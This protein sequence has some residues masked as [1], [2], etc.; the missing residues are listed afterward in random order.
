MPETKESQLSEV[1]RRGS[2]VGL[3][4]QL[5]AA[6]FTFVFSVLIARLFHAS[7]TGIFFEAIAI[8]A[9]ASNIADI[10]ADDGLIYLMPL[11][12]RSGHLQRLQNFLPK[13]LV[14]IFLFGS[15]FASALFVWAPNI[16]QIFSHHSQNS[17]LVLSLRI[18][19]PFVPLAALVDVLLAGS[20]GLGRFWPALFVT[21]L[22][23]PLLRLALVVIF[24][25]SGIGLVSVA[26]AWGVPVALGVIVLVALLRSFL[27]STAKIAKPID[28]LDKTLLSKFWRVSAPRGA[29]S[30]F[31]LGLVW[32]DVLLVGAIDS[33][34]TAGIYAIANRYLLILTMV[35]AAVGSAFAS[36]ISPLIS[37]RRYKELG[38]LYQSATA[39]IMAAVWPIALLMALFSPVL[40]GIFGKGFGHG[41]S[42]LRVLAIMMMFVSATGNNTAVLV[43][44]GKSGQSLLISIATLGINVALNLIWIPRIGILGAA[45]AWAVSLIFA[46]IAVSYSLWHSYRLTPFS[47]SWNKVAIGSLLVVGG[48]G[49]L[50]VAIDGAHFG[51]L[52]GCAAVSLPLYCFYIWHNRSIF[53]R[54][55][56]QP[57][58]G[59]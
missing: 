43:L 47:S 30:I 29:S 8:F 36:Q 56:S 11:L 53:T 23:V 33:V 59:I 12:R 10:G 6:I 45:Y 54:P 1:L 18:L 31:V 14:I 21:S 58:Q 27:R 32:V 41:D 20:R 40:M 34:R 3:I 35:I 7:G 52:V 39:W 15:V 5:L 38:H 25:A 22:G 16:A 24:F 19:A 49:A 48:L 17:D 42:S 26:I 2:L 13:L 50:G 44:S 57:S 37:D 28:E 51:A 46:N 4:A 9:I 55:L